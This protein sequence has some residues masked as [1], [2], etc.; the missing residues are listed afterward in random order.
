MLKVVKR[1]EVGQ[2][3]EKWDSIMGEVGQYCGR[4]GTMREKGD[5]TIGEV[6]R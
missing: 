1:G 4:S 2:S 6:G 3:R 5:S